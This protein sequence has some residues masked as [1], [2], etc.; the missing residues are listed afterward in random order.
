MNGHRSLS[1][2]ASTSIAGWFRIVMLENPNPAGG[3]SS[4]VDAARPM[5][6]LCVEL[7]VQPFG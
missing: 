3:R 7:K 5:A 2:L 4:F 1:S 6:F